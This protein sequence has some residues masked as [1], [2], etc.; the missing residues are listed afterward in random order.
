MHIKRD[1]K[2][3]T[4]LGILPWQGGWVSMM[5][6]MAMRRTAI[7]ILPR[8]LLALQIREVREQDGVSSA[9]P[10]HTHAHT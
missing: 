3:F 7:I 2:R 1:S 6:H 4:Q 9:T 5:M 8:Y 10:T